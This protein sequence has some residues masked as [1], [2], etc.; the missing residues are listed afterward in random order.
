MNTEKTTISLLRGADTIGG[1]CI[2]ISHGGESIILDYG[3]PLMESGGAPVD[4]ESVKN[5]T[6]DNG[7][8]LNV[9]ADGRTP[10]AFIISHAHPDHFG[11]VDHVSDNI[12]VFLSEAAKK[13]ISVGNVF[14]DETMRVKRV[15]S[16]ST[17]IPGK[18]FE[19]GPFK[20]T[21]F[22]MDHSAFGAC[23]ILVEVDGKKI[24]YTG[25]FRGHG[26]KRSVNDYV[27]KA[28]QNPDVLLMEGTTLDDGHPATF[29]DEASVEQALV[30]LINER[31]A[32]VF[33]S[34]AGSN[35]DRIV[36]LY[37]AAKRTG[38]VMVID[39]YQM[40]LLEQ[41]KEFSNGLPPH[42]DDSLKVFYPKN[43]CDAVAKHLGPEVL[44]RYKDRQLKTDDIDFTSSAYIFR[45]SNFI[46]S[47]L[48]KRFIEQNV[49]PELVYSMWQGYKEKQKIFT[50]I[51]KL[52]GNKWVYIHTSEHA[53]TKTLKKLS[54]DI[55]PKKLI[56][57][58]TVRGKEFSKHFKNVY[59]MSNGEELDI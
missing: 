56:P 40:Y 13:I 50:D 27:V 47:K 46:S 14:Y 5:P 6:I 48:C 11:L 19:I 57:I 15:S 38:R 33:V 17:Y 3:M 37:R 22:L 10:L 39:I 44:Y 9:S 55:K 36:S 52:V 58:H 45:L 7:V 25:D 24:F 41:L 31:N 1:S 49:V 42:K 21:A 34:G 16:C 51:E 20:L 4:I 12:P 29:P 35:I 8:L 28:V 18:S 30:D 23:S 32:P 43:Q 53:Y 54:E 26:R 59:L 2:K